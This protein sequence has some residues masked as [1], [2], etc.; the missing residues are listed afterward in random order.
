MS[1]RINT[2]PGAGE[3]LAKTAML[4]S[5]LCVAAMEWNPKSSNVRPTMSPLTVR[6]VPRVVGASTALAPVYFH[7]LVQSSPPNT[8][9]PPV[10]LASSW[11]ASDSASCTPAV[12]ASCPGVDP[13]MSASS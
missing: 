13:R 4:D 12:P 2:N 9:T 7:P 8:V 11:A 1:H 10:K 6:A 3:S 5:P